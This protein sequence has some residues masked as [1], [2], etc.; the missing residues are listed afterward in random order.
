MVI[1]IP[2]IFA[3]EVIWPPARTPACQRLLVGKVE[4]AVTSNFRNEAVFIWFSHQQDVGD[5]S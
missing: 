2:L 3:G 5:F 1:A 4:G